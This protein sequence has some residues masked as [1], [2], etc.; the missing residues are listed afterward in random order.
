MTT[1]N[2]RKM[3]LPRRAMLMGAI[4]AIG[5]SATAR[6]DVGDTALVDLQ[7]IDRE[8]GQA[9][10]VWR[11]AGRMYVAGQPGERYSLRVTNNTGGR[12][13]VVMSVDG[14]N[15]VT[16]E[17]AGYQQRGYVFQPH[18]SYDVSGWRKSDSQV[19]AFTFAPLNRSYAARTGRPDDVGVIGLAVFRERVM[20][21]VA[22]SISPQ[23][24][25]RGAA[26]S[27]GE[28][29]AQSR[30]PAPRAFSPPPARVAP[31]PEASAKLGTGH[32]PR[33]WSAATT[34][35]FT[36][37][38]SYPEFIHRLEYDSRERLVASGVI[39]RL[40]PSPAQP[41]PF[42]AGPGYVPDPPRGR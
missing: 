5:L 25:E 32:G 38:T 10:R 3:N 20:V 13:L 22:P 12:V 24:R 4:C 30:A 23:Y 39:P 17:T 31:V 36:R 26:D 27:A 40:R 9:A 7:V 6:A 8:T 35:A 16:G 33:E 19:A 1:A 34:V 29:G 28:V 18:E 11:H 41:R 14:V 15:I 21:P 42:P 37:A 2:D